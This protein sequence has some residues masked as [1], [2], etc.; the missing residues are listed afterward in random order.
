MSILKGTIQQENTIF[1]ILFTI[2]IIP[3]YSCKILTLINKRSEVIR[4]GINIFIKIL[5][6]LQFYM[7][8]I[9]KR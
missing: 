2:N 4:K 3:H 9:H 6:D 7:Y 5:K 8:N 1:A